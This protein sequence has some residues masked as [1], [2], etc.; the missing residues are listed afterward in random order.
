MSKTFEAMQ[1]SW[2]QLCP[3][4]SR[5][6]QRY[7]RAEH[8]F[9]VLNTWAVRHTPSFGSKMFPLTHSPLCTKPIC[10][11]MGGSG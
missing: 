5:E 8:N 7:S 9:P 1:S 6:L 4:P 3:T 2:S 10:D 11:F